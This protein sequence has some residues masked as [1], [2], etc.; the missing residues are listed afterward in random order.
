MDPE[1]AAQLIKVKRIYVDS[2]GDDSISQQ[3]QAMVVNSLAES[4]RFIVTENKD[5][6]DAVLK[7]TGIEKTAQELHAIAEGTTVATAAGSEHGQVTGHVSGGTG[8]VSSSS[9]GGFSSRKLASSDSQASTETV[10]D[11]RLAVRLVSSGGDVIWTTTKESK[12]AKYKGASADVADQ[13][14][15]QLLWD[16]DRLVQAK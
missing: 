14:V 7:G 15:K 1:I 3:L 6:A 2:F 10:N 8:S 12:G 9:D 4:K 11:A 5:R 13:V 16:L